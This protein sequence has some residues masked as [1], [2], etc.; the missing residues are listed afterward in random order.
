MALQTN[1]KQSLYLL[2]LGPHGAKKGQKRDK[3][4]IFLICAC[5]MNLI[6]YPLRLVI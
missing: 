3:I 6:F 1:R 4:E 2:C 5:S